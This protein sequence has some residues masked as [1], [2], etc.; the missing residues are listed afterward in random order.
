MTQRRGNSAPLGKRAAPDEVIAVVDVAV[1]VRD[2]FRPA[3]RSGHPFQGGGLDPMA[4]P[5]GGPRS[6]GRP[7]P[8]DAWIP[9]RLPTVRV[10]GIP[11]HTG[12]R[13]QQT[14]ITTSM[15]NR[16]GHEDSP[17]RLKP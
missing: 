3:G 13:E 17:T 15:A 9:T 12:E 11:T 1:A 8:T 2:G 6:W 14:N 10:H 7:K 16:E 5:H 4:A